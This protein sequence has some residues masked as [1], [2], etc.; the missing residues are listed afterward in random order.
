MKTITEKIKIIYNFFVIHVCMYLLSL[1]YIKRVFYNV[2]N[3]YRIAYLTVE[4]TLPIN[5]DF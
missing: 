4:F 1:K 3:D 5:G 2:F